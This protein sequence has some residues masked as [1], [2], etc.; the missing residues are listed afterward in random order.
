MSV[1]PKRPSN[2]KSGMPHRTNKREWWEIEMITDKVT[3]VKPLEYWEDFC[4]IYKEVSKIETETVE[5]GHKNIRITYHKDYNKYD[6]TLHVF[7]IHFDRPITEAEKDFAR[8]AK[9]KS[10]EE[11]K[12]EREKIKANELALL[13]KLKTKYES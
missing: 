7:Q 13:L 11:R 9:L 5:K 3:I 2:R 6:D 1:M 10:R 4:D 12:K 8:A